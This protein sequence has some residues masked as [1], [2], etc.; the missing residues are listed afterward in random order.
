MGD[1]NN[2][3]KMNVFQEYFTMPD[4]PSGLKD[5]YNGLGYTSQALNQL[6][7]LK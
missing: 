5:D 2:L 6:I 7:L 3:N 4:S 1:V